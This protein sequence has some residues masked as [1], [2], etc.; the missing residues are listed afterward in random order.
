MLRLGRSAGRVITGVF[1][2]ATLAVAC[3]APAQAGRI[4]IIT[5]PPPPGGGI[6]PVG[7]D[8]VY[9]F[10]FNVYLQAG[11]DIYAFDSFTVQAAMGVDQTSPTLQPYVGDPLLPAGD[12]WAST[13]TPLPGTS[14]WPGTPNQ[15]VTASDVNWQLLPSNAG[16]GVPISNCPTVDNPDPGPLY[17]GTFGFTSYTD[18]SPL[19]FGQSITFTYTVSAHTCDGA[20]D[21]E[22]GSFI[23][24]RGAVPEP[25]SIALLGL[26][27]VLPGVVARRRRAAA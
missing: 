6:T 27:V 16:G 22:T 15:Q 23:L 10:T 7:G 24:T 14:T 17:L 3:A 20:E 21:T 1:F 11:Y 12:K 2:F 25:T 8:P 9:N 26:G 13:I 18:L 5:P 4:I 19:D